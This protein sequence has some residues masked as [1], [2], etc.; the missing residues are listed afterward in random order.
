MNYIGAGDP[1]CAKYALVSMFI[2]RDT[3]PKKREV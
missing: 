3:L 2:D 1:I